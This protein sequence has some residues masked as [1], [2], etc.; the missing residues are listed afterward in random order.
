MGIVS[1]VAGLVTLGREEGLD[2]GNPFQPLHLHAG[3]LLVAGPERKHL[4]KNMLG[5][6]DPGM[7]SGH[8]S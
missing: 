7:F 8:T 1:L 6:G 2:S 5:E 4:G 3:R